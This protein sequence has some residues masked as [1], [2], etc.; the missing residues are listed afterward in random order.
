MRSAGTTAAAG[1]PAGRRTAPAEPREG[2]D[3][4]ARIV[5]AA[6]RLFAE[7][8]YDGTSVKEICRAAGVNIAAIHYHFG[9][10]ENLYRHIVEQFD[11]ERLERA[12]QVLEPPQ[13]AE[14]LTVRLELFLR[15]T[16][17]AMIRQPAI[18][19][20]IQRGIEMF[21]ATSEAVFRN[22][23]HRHFTGLVEFLT[24]ARKNKLLAADVDAFSAAGFL[25]SQVQHQTVIDKI[26]KK[27][28]GLSLQDGKYRTRWVRQT[29]RLFLHGVAPK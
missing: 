2:A 24:Q 3:T 11:A 26:K 14:E 7:R 19:L 23:I 25:M 13:N 22:T 21:D 9:L 16:L 27:Y 28:F 18:F 5:S 12:R 15:Q 1:R 17:E 10:K 20:L 4:A 6:T 8:G 29:V